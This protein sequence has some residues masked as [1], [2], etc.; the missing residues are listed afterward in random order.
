MSFLHFE[1]NK[2]VK[3]DGALHHSVVHFQNFVSV[4][5]AFG[6]F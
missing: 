4:M 5:D 3:V 6:N 2:N 1:T